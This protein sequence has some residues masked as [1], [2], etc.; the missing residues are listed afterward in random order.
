MSKFLGIN[1]LDKLTMIISRNY[2]SVRSGRGKGKSQGPTIPQDPDISTVFPPLPLHLKTSTAK[3][4]HEPSSSS[5]LT[6]SEKSS[7]KGKR[8]FAFPNMDHQGLPLLNAKDCFRRVEFASKMLQILK[9]E[10]EIL[11]SILFTDEGNFHLSKSSRKPLDKEGQSKDSPLKGIK[12]KGRKVAESQ[13]LPQ[14]VWCGMTSKHVIG[15]YFF[16][17]YVTGEIFLLIF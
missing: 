8:N 16:N 3:Q 14:I 9:K 15:P 17:S 4:L 12:P 5:S 13:S 7:F 2:S 1:A 11:D 6:T 10:P